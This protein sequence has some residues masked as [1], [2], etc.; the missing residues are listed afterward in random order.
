VSYPP[1]QI[2]VNRYKTFYKTPSMMSIC[3][4]LKKIV[5]PT[6]NVEVTDNPRRAGPREF[7]ANM[8]KSVALEMMTK[9]IESRR[10]KNHLQY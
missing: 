7:L 9:P 10:V 5:L 6:S 8:A 1:V 3:K 4:I 2:R